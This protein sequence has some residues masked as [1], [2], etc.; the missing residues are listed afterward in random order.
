MHLVILDGGGAG[1]G[2]GMWPGPGYSVPVEDTWP[3]LGAQ[4]G[5]P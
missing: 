4:R 3:L 1:S 2:V 5:Q